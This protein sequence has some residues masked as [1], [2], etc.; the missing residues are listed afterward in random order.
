[1]DDVTLA[2]LY[3][4]R[5]GHTEVIAHCVGEGASA[6]DG[7]TATLFSVADTAADDLDSFD[8]VIFGCPTHFGGI[9][10]EMK[11]LMDQTIPQYDGERWRDKI[12]AGFTCG[13]APSGDKQ[14]CLI[15]IAV[16]AMQQGMIWVGIDAMKDV[17]TGQGKPVGYN[18]WDSYLGMMA[19]APGDDVTPDSPPEA[20]RETARL[21]G[22]RI[23]VAT[24]CWRRG[25][26]AD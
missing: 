10:A 13:G 6:I 24:R 5:L 21:F 19:T 2:V 26:A 12:A 25:K 9:S 11:Q 4:S 23:A 18:Q 17:R 22:R 14:S 8:G 7:V 3:H 15:Q 1:M 20:D 16:F